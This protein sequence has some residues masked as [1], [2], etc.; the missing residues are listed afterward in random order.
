MADLVAV[1]P[2]AVAAGPLERV[3]DLPGGASRLTSGSSGIA[4][5]WVG[6]TRVLEAGASTGATPGRLL[7]R[8]AVAA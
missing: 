6:G 5:V 4:V 2:E 1:D 7:R 8:P 3:W